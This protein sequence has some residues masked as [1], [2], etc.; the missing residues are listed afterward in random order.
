MASLKV[1]FEASA[2][3]AIA[4][5]ESFKNKT[6]SIFSGISGIVTGALAFAGVSL[7]V[8][9][10][11]STID[12]LD[13]LGKASRNLGVSAEELQKY[14]HAARSVNLPVE[15]LQPS[16]DKMRKMVGDAANGMEEPKKK[17]ALLGLTLEQLRG[18]TTAEQFDLFSRAILG[19][20]DPT[21]Q[22]TAAMLIFGE[23]GA[24]LLNFMRE[25]KSAGADL[26]ARGGV[27]SAEQV[28]AAEDF[29]QACT[30]IAASL[31]GWAVNSGFIQQLKDIA[32][33]LASVASNAE[34]MKKLGIEDRTGKISNN[35]N[36]QDARFA[37]AMME[38]N[39]AMLPGAPAVTVKNPYDEQREVMRTDP[40]TDDEVKKAAEQ[41]EKER[42]EA[43]ERERIRRE[44][45]EKAEREKKQRLDDA[46][47][48][49]L[50]DLDR[51]A[52]GKDA[53][54]EKRRQSAI[55]QEIAKAERAAKSSGQELD[56]E[57]RKKV[58]DAAGRAFDA[59]EKRSTE[60]IDDQ[61]AALREKYELQ[62]QIIAGKAREAAI[63]QEINRA[64]KAAKDSGVELTDEQRAA[65]RDAAG[66]NFDLEA[67]RQTSHIAGPQNAVYS[68]AR[69]RMGGILG[70]IG[71][72]AKTDYAKKSSQ[73][74]DNV[75]S[76]L[77]QL[78]DKIPNRTEISEET[79]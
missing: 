43:A 12:A 33:G 20:K 29:N 61:I 16:F 32:E 36:E 41:R 4:A 46:I 48:S 25:Y 53:P 74:L 64:E 2:S 17:L 10:L 38:G 34:K 44:A 23:Q 27:I 55:D 73:T 71:G 37:A 56:P 26:E 67:S 42:A 1:V 47:N 18:K 54:R 30:N 76:K 19:I 21:E 50:D 66:K 7:G 78:Y 72:G 77:D 65:L 59:E 6:K 9:A 3:K 45:Q 57:R 40:I 28:Q 11:K 62:Q 70:S 35:K 52:T 14:Q 8:G 75:R 79:F 68:D 31:Q 39:A 63:Q 49:Q 22:A 69:L 51:R 60:K 5:F 13:N 24:K 15:Q 58:E